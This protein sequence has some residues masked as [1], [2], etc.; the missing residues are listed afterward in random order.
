MKEDK[1]EILLGTHEILDELKDITVRVMRELP[2]DSVKA[3]GALKWI[4]DEFER[5]T[6]INLSTVEVY[7]K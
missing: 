4:M 7:S 3:A 5:E 6:G 2:E 1:K